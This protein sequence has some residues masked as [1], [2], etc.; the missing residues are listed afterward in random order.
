MGDWEY[1]IV[2][3]VH[4]QDFKGYERIRLGKLAGTSWSWIGL[5]WL[6]CQ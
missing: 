4:L 2:I 1:A 6:D 5:E 3:H